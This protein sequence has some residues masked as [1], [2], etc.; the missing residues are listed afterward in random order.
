MIGHVRDVVKATGDR[1]S[2]CSAE[3]FH[4]RAAAESPGGL[5]PALSDVLKTIEELT[6]RI[7][8]YDKQIEQLS[9][10]RYAETA[11][12]RAIHGVGPITALAY[13]LTLEEADRF[14]RSRSV[15][16]FP[17]LAPRRDKSG[18]I[19]KQLRIS[20][21][22]DEYLRRLLVGCAQYI[23]GPHG[24]DCLLRRF[25]EKL[26]RRGGKNAKRRAT[27]AVAR[28]LAV[29]LHRLWQSGDAYDPFYKPQVTA[30]RVA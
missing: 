11:N 26:A 15:G 17:G 19:D 20:K 6:V 3:A 14:D 5:R 2:S 9:V 23:L 29:L 7:R 18:R 8:H 22:G 30:R 21:A 27:V 24:P 1:V 13:V 16:P 4:Y 10:E 25:G 28:K 12:L